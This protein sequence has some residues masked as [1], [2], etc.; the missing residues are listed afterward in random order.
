MFEALGIAPRILDPI[1]ENDARGDGFLRAQETYQ[2]PI[3]TE[4]TGWYPPSG[5]VDAGAWGNDDQAGLTLPQSPF[6]GSFQSGWLNSS[7]CP[8]SGY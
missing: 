4:G 1:V 5:N 8:F 2:I 7:R 3:W 6:L